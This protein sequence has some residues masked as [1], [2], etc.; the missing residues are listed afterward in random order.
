MLAMQCTCFCDSIYF[1]NSFCVVI[2]SKLDVTRQDCTSQATACSKIVVK[3]MNR[4]S[5]GCST[6]ALRFS[7]AREWLE[8]LTQKKKKV[9]LKSHED[10]HERNGLLLLVWIMWLAN[11]VKGARKKITTNGIDKLY[12]QLFRVYTMYKCT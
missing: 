4:Q 10:K 7:A 3:Y 9:L 5:N 6:T 8:Q 2:L 11:A 12:N 1:F